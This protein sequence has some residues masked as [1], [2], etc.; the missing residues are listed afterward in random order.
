MYSIQA[1]SIMLWN[2]FDGSRFIGETESNFSVGFIG[3]PGD[4]G[5]GAEDS[6]AATFSLN[7][8]ISFIKLSMSSES[9]LLLDFLSFVVSFPPF[10]PFLRLPPP[11]DSFGETFFVAFFVFFFFSSLALPSFCSLEF[12]FVCCSF[13]RLSASSCSSSS[14]NAN[15]LTEHEES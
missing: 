9:L 4:C 1:P 7:F 5:A 3:F 12:L 6:S 10:F 8:S 2:S 15:L 14:R 13:S 11:A